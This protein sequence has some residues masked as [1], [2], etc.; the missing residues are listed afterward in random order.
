MTAPGEGVPPPPP[1]APELSVFSHILIIVIEL[2]QKMRVE[3]F[4]AEEYSGL[5]Q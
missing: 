3:I 4:L 2:M 5:R 1:A